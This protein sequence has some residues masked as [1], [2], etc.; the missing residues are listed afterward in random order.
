MFTSKWIKGL[1]YVVAYLVLS[2]IVS[3][4]T[5]GGHPTVVEWQLLG[6]SL[7]TT[8][9]GYIVKPT[10]SDP[11]PW[12]NIN[13]SGFWNG[14]LVTLGTFAGAILTIIIKSWPKS[15]EEWWVIIGLTV[16]S[17]GAYILK[18]FF[19]TSEGKVTVTNKV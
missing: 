18:A 15:M 5:T 2:S 13:W 6:T 1:V 11:G 14:L 12:M 16:T 19:T 9:I 17:F 8:I 4:F 7:L 10:N 3:F